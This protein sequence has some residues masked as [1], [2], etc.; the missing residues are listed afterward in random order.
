MHALRCW[1][2]LAFLYIIH[3][4]LWKGTS[5]EF[6]SGDFQKGSSYTWTVT[7]GTS[8]SDFLPAVCPSVIVHPSSQRKWRN[9]FG[10]WD[11]V[12]I[13]FYKMYI[14]GGLGI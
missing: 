14:F 5:L 7:C 11:A 1:K 9:M 8:L 10:T 3:R 6:N 2:L 12:K 4:Y 13:I